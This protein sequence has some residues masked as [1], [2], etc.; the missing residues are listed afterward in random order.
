[1]IAPKKSQSLTPSISTPN[2]TPVLSQSVYSKYVDRQKRD[3]FQNAINNRDPLALP[4][5]EEQGASMQAKLIRM[6]NNPEYQK[7]TPKERIGVRAR[8]YDMYVKPAYEKAGA[9]PPDP[10]TWLLGTTKDQLGKID[11]SQFFESKS[12]AAA[13]DLI[14]SAI[15]GGSKL[16]QAGAMVP[17]KMFQI[18]SGL[19]QYFT[20]KISTDW[21]TRLQADQK[22][23]NKYFEQ[24]RSAVG[25]VANSQNFYL[26]NHP[27]KGF[28]ASAPSWVGDQVAMLPL[29]EALNP[30]SETIG[31]VA[32]AT[33]SKIVPSLTATL[34]KSKVGQFVG[35]RLL[36]A[37]SGFLAGKTLGESN[38]E[39]G[40]DAAAFAVG[41]AIGEGIGSLFKRKEIPMTNLA[42]DED[43]K[44][45]TAQNIAM[46]GRPFVEAIHEQA[47]L[48][49]GQD[50]VLADPEKQKLLPPGSGEKVAAE[51][52]SRE[53]NDSLA[54]KLV[55]AEKLSLRSI[56]Q[57]HFGKPWD[58]LSKLQREK[59]KLRRM[60]L[61]TE[62]EYE[63]PSHAP[64]LNKK[65][66]EH[67][68]EKE[69]ATSPIFVAVGQMIKD[70][71]PEAS[72]ASIVNHSQVEA[73]QILTGIKDPIKTAEKVTT[74]RVQDSKLP[75]ELSKL[76]FNYGYKDSNFN[77]EFNDP[78]DKAAYVISQNR[79]DQK[80]G[81]RK[82]LKPSYYQFMDYLKKQFPGK[83]EDELIAYGQSV[84]EHIKERAKSDKSED[85]VLHID[86]QAPKTKS[87]EVSRMAKGIKVTAE[88]FGL[89]R[90][91]SISYFRNNGV[92]RASDGTVIGGRDKRP[93]NVR[94]KAENFNQFIETLK[95]SDGDFIN[96]ESPYHRM[97][98]HWAN[99]DSLP[100][101]VRDKLLREMKQWQERQKTPRF[102]KA[103]DFNKEADWNLV[104]LTKLA[105]SGRLSSEGNVFKSTQTGGQHVMTQWQEQLGTEVEQS[106]FAYLKE[107]LKL[108]PE[109]KELLENAMQLLQMN[110]SNAKTP[111]EWLQY[112]KA[113]NEH[114]KLGGI[115]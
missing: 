113:I 20:S 60:E 55:Q 91:D 76:K 106:E 102:M 10:K 14:A 27:R 103:E 74:A 65:E 75:E 33:S 85:A 52:T 104:H 7:L 67:D 86:S 73:N 72:E 28:L 24:M 38:K 110:R 47:L 96:F 4:T 26:E 63:L 111:E 94:L 80:T 109:Q 12:E 105:Q 53:Q 88:E 112:N 70:S 57:R 92:R 37:T 8:F 97:L 18:S 68:I 34:M 31:K 108:F 51:R 15:V 5:L 95:E 22:T 81:T 3:K 32:V 115:Y 41:G 77:L 56:A 6:Q 69:T 29:Y 43:I 90:A 2:N 30:V 45:W 107:T 83:S 59:V 66:V 93:W 36:D 54:H 100:T 25:T 58:N 39:S 62:A 89:K 101:P 40:G 42:T 78:R 46:G 114:L 9:K 48:E 82:T 11:P 44:A 61:V 79:W 16:I 99:R 84:R 98:Y 71:F 17:Q 50:L 49:H 13:H 21:S 64:D 35:R 87:S 1:M 23:E 19:A